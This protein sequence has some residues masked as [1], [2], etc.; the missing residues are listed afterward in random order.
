MKIDGVAREANDL[1]MGDE[2]R[3]VIY[4]KIER[5]I[6]PRDLKEKRAQLVA[7]IADIDETLAKLEAADLGIKG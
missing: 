6:I 5:V 1:H 2:R 3:F 7:E 4:E